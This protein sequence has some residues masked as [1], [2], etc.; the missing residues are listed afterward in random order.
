ML[1]SVFLKIGNGKSHAQ[2]AEAAS[3]DNTG[4]HSGVQTESI[5]HNRAEPM[6]APF[7]VVD[8]AHRRAASDSITNVRV[9]ILF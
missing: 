7:T 4:I 1:R 5:D 6:H 8:E 3:K 9:I 2:N